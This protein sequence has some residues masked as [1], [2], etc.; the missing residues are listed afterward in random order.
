LLQVGLFLFDGKRRRVFHAILASS[1]DALLTELTSAESNRTIFDGWLRV[2]K[3]MV[4]SKR[5]RA[6]APPVSLT[7]PKDRFG[8]V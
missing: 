1:L 3:R 5:P 4:G 6:Y 7:R 2:W 8:S